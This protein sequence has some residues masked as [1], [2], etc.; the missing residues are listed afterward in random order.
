MLCS[1]LCGG[2]LRLQSCTALIFT[3]KWLVSACK[4][5]IPLEWNRWSQWRSYWIPT[6]QRSRYI[7]FS[8]FI[9]K[10]HF[11]SILMASWETALVRSKPN[12]RGEF[13]FVLIYSDDFCFGRF[14]TFTGLHISGMS[15]RSSTQRGSWKPS[16]VRLMGG[17]D[18]ILPAA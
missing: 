18:M 8:R 6:S 15:L 16:L 3:I 7:H 10:L 9:H 11:L 1:L 5:S 14:T 12:R 13:C 2:K 4:L 17:K